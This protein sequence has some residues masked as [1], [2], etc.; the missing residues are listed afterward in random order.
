MS[1]EPTLGEVMRQ[2]RALVDQVRDLVHEVRSDYV[3]KEVY[4]ARHHALTRRVDDLERETEDREKARV[5]F[6]R[7]IVGGVLIGLVLM[8]VQLVVTALMFTGGLR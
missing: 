4:D 3:R 8:L 5:A 6:Q 2:V 7:Q 1:D